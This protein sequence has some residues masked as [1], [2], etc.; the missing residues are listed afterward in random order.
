MLKGFLC[1][2]ASVFLYTM[3]R[4]SISLIISLMA[5]ALLGVMAMQYYFIRQSFQL[6][7]QLFDES[8]M[9]A[10]NTVALKVEKDEALRFLNEREFQE[11][12]L[13]ERRQKAKER[14]FEDDESLLYVNK[15]KMKR[16][17]LSSEF[18]ALEKQVKRRYPG[19]VLLDNDFY[20]TYMKDPALRAHVK[21]EITVQQAYD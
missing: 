7:T 1:L 12:K 2:Y 11:N 18:K 5:I 9:A 16:Q 4:K 15:M 3:N 6:K 13:R 17:K 8:V 20:E 19:A 21:Y 10:I 14:S